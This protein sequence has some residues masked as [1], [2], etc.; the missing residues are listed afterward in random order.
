MF[1]FL[2][3]P[4][5]RSLNKFRALYRSR[6]SLVNDVLVTGVAWQATEHS[7]WNPYLTGGILQTECDVA[8]TLLVCHAGRGWHANLGPRDPAPKCR[9]GG[10]LIYLNS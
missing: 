9:V 7:R 1:K 8:E 5:I 10:L 3:P 4:K 2:A 6:S